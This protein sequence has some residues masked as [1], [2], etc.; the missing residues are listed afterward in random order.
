LDEVI[1]DYSA[2]VQPNTIILNLLFV[3]Y[4]VRRLL[5]ICDARLCKNVGRPDP[6]LKGGAANTQ[7]FCTGNCMV[8]SRLEVPCQLATIFQ[9]RR[10]ESQNERGA[11]AALSVLRILVPSPLA[12]SVHG[13]GAGVKINDCQFCAAPQRR[14]GAVGSQLRARRYLFYPLRC[15][16]GNDAAIGPRSREL[17]C[18]H[19]DS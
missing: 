12:L 17:A 18:R 8:T 9:I 3:V 16:G 10:C 7:G 4:P 13:R 15:P 6:P 19:G 14:P 5:S 2:S 11:R 1:I